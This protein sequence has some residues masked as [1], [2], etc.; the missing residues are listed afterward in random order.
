MRR[1][2]PL[3]PRLSALLWLLGGGGGPA[4]AQESG[5]PAEA[6]DGGERREGY[7][8]RLAARIARYRSAR[9]AGAGASGQAASGLI[10]GWQSRL[11]ED[12][13]FDFTVSAD[14]LDPDFEYRYSF[15]IT[16]GGSGGIG[17]DSMC[18]F[19]SEAVSVPQGSTS[20]ESDPITLH[21][22]IP[23]T[24][25]VTV[26]L[27]EY[28]IGEDE[29]YLLETDPWEI[30]VD[31]DLVPVLPP[32]DDRTYKVAESVNLRL[33]PATGG[34]PPLRYSASGLPNGLTFNNSSRRITGAPTTEGDYTVTYR[35]R[36]DDGDPDSEEFDIT[37]RCGSLTFNDSVSGMTWT[38]NTRISTFTLPEA[39]VASHCTVS[40]YAL[41]PPD[42]P[43]GV[44]RSARRVSGTPSV[45][46]ERTRYAWT[47]TASDGSKAE[48]TFYLAVRAAPCNP[49]F[50][51]SV[52]GM[53][54]TQNT[55]ISTFTLPQAFVASHCM[56]SGYALNP[57][58]LPDGV[59]RSARRVSGTPSVSMG[60]TRYAWTATASDGSKAELTFY[61][62]V[63]PPPC[64]P[65]FNDSV[66]GMTWM[67]NTP[68]TTFTLPEA[69]VASHC[70][71]SGYALNPPD[72]PDGVS[73]SARRVS[74]TPSVSMERTRYAWT[75]TASDG[76]KAELT[77]YLAV[78]AAPCNPRFDDSVSGMT[79]MQNTRIS[80]FT[81]PQAFVASHCMVSGYALNPPDLPDGVS[82]SARRVSGTPS[83]SMG[84]TRYAWTATASD[85]SK[86]ELTFYITVSPPPCNPRFN[87]SV[88]GMTWMQNTPITTFTL[89][90]A[91]VA[92]HC[93]VS[94]YALNPPDLPDGVSRSARRVS[95][96]PSVSMERTRY[97]WTAT[98]SD[99]SKAELTFD[100]TVEEE[101]LTPTFGDAAVDP[102]SYTQNSPITPLTLPSA[103]GGNGTLTYDLTPDLPAG[104]EFDADG[105][106]PCRAIRT[107]CGTPTVSLPAAATFTLTATDADRDTAPLTFDITVTPPP[108]PTI[109]I[110]AGTSPVTEGEDVEFTLTASSAPAG[111]L[112]VRLNTIEDGL[113][114]EDGPPVT[115]TI[116]PD[117]ASVGADDASVSLALPTDNDEIDEQN[118]S[119][120]V[121]IDPGTGYVVGSPSSATV[122][123]EDNDVPVITIARH[124]DTDIVID[125]GDDVTF[126]LEAD[127][128]PAT[129]LA[130]RVRLAETRQGAFLHP[131][132]SLTRSITIQ[133]EHT[134]ADFT[135][136][137]VDDTEDEHNENIKAEVA[138]DDT[139]YALGN[140]SVALVRVLD[141]DLP[142]PPA[143]LRANGDLDSDDK[144]TLRWEPVEGATG[145]GVRYAGETCDSLGVCTHGS[146]QTPTDANL[147]ITDQTIGEDTVKQASLGEL[148]EETLYRIQVRSTVVSDS[149]WY[150]GN[151]TLVFPTDSPLGGGTV[152]TAPFHGYQRKNA[153][154][155][156]E[157]RYVV[158]TGTISAN[159]TTPDRNAVAIARDIEDA[160][161]K[162]ES[163]VI[164]DRGGHNIV[165]ATSYRPPGGENC[166]HPLIPGTEVITEIPSEDGR[167]EVKFV[168]NDRIG[169]ACNLFGD[170]PPP[171]CW[172]S[173]SWETP[174]IQ[175]IRSGAILVNASRGANYW[176]AQVGG[177]PGCTR[178]HELVIHEAGH[179]FGIGNRTGFDFNRH[180]INTE[181]SVMSYE[182]PDRDCE[183]QAYD[184]VAS[185]ALYQSRR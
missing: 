147:T 27:Y 174:G 59:S 7:E 17:F 117:D 95:G 84:R 171:G 14:G 50:D 64:N 115:I 42:L 126:R 107:L 137:T 25:T 56:V 1:A 96:T 16:T 185:M 66:S 4:R 120:T 67:Q 133:A 82:R 166:T 28:S 88:S 142:D 163:T 134:T 19:T 72:L 165:T 111:V 29:E 53:T 136:R 40:G 52:S 99:G 34:N 79:W 57:P 114:L 162:W 146:W 118:G 106:G 68:I 35:V 155:S 61:I 30:T 10:S 156:H 175:R 75:A 44:S 69:R 160:I 178:L 130:V 157:F 37:V 33:D 127:P 98:A 144:I 85:G 132:E 135:V 38:Q 9:A 167:F 104:L 141:G 24:Y 97:A 122:T 169:R 31:P 23:G 80:T 148:T 51:D 45:S 138:P 49:R 18:S 129:D 89:P 151:P 180:P 101:D 13:S 46:M 73:R 150:Q 43:D 77:F 32:V 26:R 63:S 102:Q 105:N 140:P 91:R 153:Q 11:T 3:R 55:R 94:G 90:E 139:R 123:V 100:I 108:L 65:R 184:I 93:T 12:E 176:K 168:S 83:V 39:F 22:C 5:G 15:L 86:A 124:P 116:G 128:A 113:F 20:H 172:R 74:G 21:A 78:R 119:V 81:L 158:C 177:A 48:L 112:V 36:D 170:A 179:A 154:G 131:G 76:S 87:D 121:R 8:E 6:Q 92:S 145:Y 110:T 159:L 161:E 143:E 125:E 183:P 58:D 71:V 152:A 173:R 41:N 60:R 182:D 47:A 103:T 149:F 109:T 2:S 62:T 164:W 181:H 54:W 70:T